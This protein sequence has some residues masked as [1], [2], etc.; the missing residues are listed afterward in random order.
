MA[1]RID[2]GH[3]VYLFADLARCDQGAP[4]YLKNAG[5]VRSR[6]GPTHGTLSMNLVA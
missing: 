1:R 2:R 6:S 4:H 3:V 5:S